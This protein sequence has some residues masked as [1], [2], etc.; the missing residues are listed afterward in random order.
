MN[1]PVG[2]IG[3]GL[4]GSALTRRLLA[5]N[6][7][8]VGHDPDAGKRRELAT[9]GM[10]PADNAAELWAR[11]ARILI[12]VFDTAQ[13]EAV[14]AEA[15]SHGNYTVLIC[16]TCDP[17]RIAELGPVAAAKNIAVLEAPISGT[18]RQVASGD[19]V[20]LL[21]G[22]EEVADRQDDIFR[23][24]AKRTYRMGVLGNGNR[25]KLAINLILGLNRAALAEGLVLAE[26]LGLSPAALLDAARGSAAHSQVMDIKGD[27]MVRG[28]FTPVGRVAQS[29]K[30]F[31]LIVG[32]AHVAGQSL[33]FGS[34]YLE[35][36]EEC[37]A[38]GEGDLDNSAIIRAIRR[39]AHLRRDAT[40]LRRPKKAG[41]DQC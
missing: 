10:I 22:D 33:P 6:L 5:A 24:V 30:D 32:A 15:P 11:C 19:G 23:A 21:G 20:L 12:A 2:V 31:R 1:G 34:T 3:L 35:L 18:S 7:N 4:I 27:P 26:T 29:A 8:V 40:A 36:M 38:L 9:S 25:A 41:P 14:L 17:K 16:S 13:V 28:D 39:C 37:I